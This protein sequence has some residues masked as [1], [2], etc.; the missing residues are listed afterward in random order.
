MNTEKMFVRS[1]TGLPSTLLFA[2]YIAFNQGQHELTVDDLMG[3]VM[4]KD[5]DSVRKDCETLVALGLIDIRLGERGK[6]YYHLTDSSQQFLPGM[7]PVLPAMPGV[8]QNPVPEKSETGKRMV[9]DA[10]VSVPE[11]SG[12][13]TENA[14][15]EP[16][17][18]QKTVQNPVLPDSGTGSINQDLINDDDIKLDLKKSSSSS[19]NQKTEFVT[20]M[21]QVTVFEPPQDFPTVS[22]ILTSMEML[23]GDYLTADMFADDLSPKLALAW[24]CKAWFDFQ[25]NRNF[26]NPVGLVRRRLAAKAP[27]KL[28]RLEDMPADFL[29]TLGLWQGRCDVCGQGFRSRSALSEHNLQGHPAELFD[30]EPDD[31]EAAAMPAEI[32]RVVDLSVFPSWD[33]ILSELREQMPRAR[34]DTWVRDTGP[35]SWDVQSGRL[36]IG[37]RNAYARDW[38]EERVQEKCAKLVSKLAGQPVKVEFV[39]ASGLS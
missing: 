25:S 33:A 36:E 24:V 4:V 18:S 20:E 5:S 11:K 16:K 2:I 1:I 27:R 26:T 21:R 9:I 6:K 8:L 7:M 28:T 39:C 32:Q 38:L 23:F 17:S 10:T 19:M 14:D 34:F 12:T 13:E 15:F 29:D 37:A 22:K 3:W 31:L 35:V 30:D